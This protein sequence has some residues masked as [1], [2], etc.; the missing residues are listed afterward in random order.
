MKLPVASIKGRVSRRVSPF[1]YLLQGHGEL[2]GR[3]VGQESEPAGVDATIGSS[4][5]QFAGDPEHGAVATEN[6]EEIHLAGEGGG[7]GHMS[8]SSPARRPWRHRPGVRPAAS[9]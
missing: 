4:S 9:E 8:P 3:H 2:V 7:F 6:D 1:E 5:P